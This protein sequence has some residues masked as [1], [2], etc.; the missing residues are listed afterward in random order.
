MRTDCIA[1]LRR[2]GIQTIEPAEE[3]VKSWGDHVQECARA[4]LLYDAKHSWYFGSN[5][6]GKPQVFMP[7]AGGLHR[8]RK[9]CA[10]IAA[11][12]Y[13]GFVMDAGRQRDQGPGVRSS[14]LT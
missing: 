14:V 8:Y 1:H 2:N 12:G 13:Q 11:K 6:E 10:E 7:Y 3:S 4:T 5:V 9:L